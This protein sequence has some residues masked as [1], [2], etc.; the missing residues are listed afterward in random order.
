MTDD[1]HLYDI[2]LT[3]ETLLCCTCI[4]SGLSCWCNV[5]FSLFLL[6]ATQWSVM[7]N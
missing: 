3:S 4:F 7:V 1:V 6:L 2:L 5:L